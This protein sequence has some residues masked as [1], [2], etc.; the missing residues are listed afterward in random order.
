MGFFDDLWE[1]VQDIGGA[2][3]GAVFGEGGIAERVI[4]GAIGAPGPSPGPFGVPG[5]FPG[6]LP[7]IQGPAVPTGL[8]L[9]SGTG[10]GPL[11][12]PPTQTETAELAGFG[13]PEVIA[14]AAG[15]LLESAGEA[16]LGGTPAGRFLGF[17]EGGGDVSELT[18]IRGRGTIQTMAAQGQRLPRQVVFAV[19]TPSG[20]TRIV[21]YRNMGAPV[22]YS[23]DFASV[24][25]VQRVAR[26]AKRRAGGR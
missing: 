22:L 16:L 8:A 15:S 2:I 3:G 19:P 11:L 14:G 26:R 1:G 10:L 7:P 20:G 9:G 4:G 17:A 21:A 24:R 25:R 13:L 5:T 23:G 6:G 18:S 12:P